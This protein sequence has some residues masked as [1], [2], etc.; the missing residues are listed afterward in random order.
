MGSQK[1][2]QKRTWCT[3][4]P[5]E[6]FLLESSVKGL[7]LGLAEGK[8]ALQV[9][10]AAGV[11]IT[12]AVLNLQ[13]PNT[14]NDNSPEVF[15]EFEQITAL[16]RDHFAGKAH[17]GDLVLEVWRFD[18]HLAMRLKLFSQHRHSWAHP[19]G[20]MLE[21]VMRFFDNLDGDCACTAMATAAPVATAAPLPPSST[22][23][24]GVGAPPSGSS[25][26]EMLPQLWRS[27]ARLRWA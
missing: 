24:P 21:E 3:G 12:R 7:F 20:P 14:S 10:A 22:S 4:L 9:V 19:V 13:A 27:L 15:N 16:V 23:A 11:A 17:F 25:P 2:P 26:R 5:L 6:I 8:A 1:L 18:P